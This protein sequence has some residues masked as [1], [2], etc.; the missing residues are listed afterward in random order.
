[1][2]KTFISCGIVVLFV[3]W[4]PLL[5]TL[6]AQQS[7]TVAWQCGQGHPFETFYSEAAFNQ[8]N[9]S[10]HGVGCPTTNSNMLNRNGEKMESIWTTMKKNKER[11]KAEASHKKFEDAYN[12]N[13]Q[14]IEYQ[15]M[16]DWVNAVR[17][18]EEAARLSPDDEN[19]RS[20]LKNAK[21]ALQIIQE[22]EL[23][24]QQQVQREQRDKDAVLRMQQSIQGFTQKR[25]SSISTGG[26][27]FDGGNSKIDN[28]ENGLDFMTVKSEIP[29]DLQVK[30]EQDEFD[31]MN[32]AWI[33]KQ[34]QLIQ[35]RMQSPNKWANSI[36]KSL[37]IKEPPLPYKKFSEL[38]SG[39]VLLISPNGFLGELIN[40]PD[41]LLSGNGSTASHTVLFLKE[42]NGKKL[43][44]DNTP[45]VGDINNGMGAH[46]I[47]EEQFIK[48]YGKR[49][50][51]VA[52]PAIMGL[53]QP[54]KKEEAQMLWDK[55]S[56]LVKK[57]LT[58]EP[59][60]SKN[61]IDKT[62]YGVSGDNMVCS[63]VS[64]WALV[65]VGRNISE[66]KSTVKKVMGINFG[67]AD[68][69]SDTQ[70]FIITPLALPPSK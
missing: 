9:C 32:A 66:T 11:K 21:E 59:L 16:G 60:K 20:N 41:R 10:V 8:H 36:Y 54:L 69:Y 17:L 67:P 42:V 45:G 22:K 49:E 5:I 6:K 55:A 31:K 62:N 68:F 24:K 2:Q 19:I 30:Q 35:Q 51:D 65:Q 23:Q 13:H 56:M 40:Q 28:K 18:Y 61:Y 38:Q 15:N 63:V 48:I 1:M 64:R 29:T 43:F 50:M 27:D 25:D 4:G 39:D 3:L 57:E 26:L 46:I 53:A 52:I 34:N 58:A 7:K 47:N 70:N 12:L 37:D 33:K 14:G 44:L